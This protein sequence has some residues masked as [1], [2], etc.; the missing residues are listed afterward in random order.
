MKWTSTGAR[1][2][3]NSG[4]DSRMAKCC[5]ACESSQ[6]TLF[7]GNHPGS[8]PE[9]SWLG[10]IGRRAGRRIGVRPQCPAGRPVHP[11][12]HASTHPSIHPI[13]TNKEIDAH[14]HTCERVPG[15]STV[16]EVPVYAGE[17]V[18]MEI[19]LTV[20]ESRQLMA[21]RPFMGMVQSTWNA[22]RSSSFISQR[23]VEKHDLETLVGQE[24]V[25]FQTANG[26]DQRVRSRR[27]TVSIIH[28]IGKRC[29]KQG[30]GFAW[31]PR[32][33]CRHHAGNNIATQRRVDSNLSVKNGHRCTF[34]PR[35]SC[36]W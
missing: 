8:L 30:C 11:C 20:K 6:P 12:S 13:L 3:V 25:S 32:R 10:S 17:D 14:T 7:L 24:T 4:E 19:K 26:A 33:G 23:K 21:R 36:S 2:M 9:A 15:T 35:S 34:I 31:P 27:Y 5:H 16:T 29:V 28:F 22:R 1:Q 18:I